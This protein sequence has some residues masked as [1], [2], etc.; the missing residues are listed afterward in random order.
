MDKRI[1][2]LKINE[3]VTLLNDHDESTCYLV[4]GKTRALLIDT[5]NGW[6]NMAALC[7]ELTPLPVTVVNTHGHCDHIFGNVY[8]PE[9]RLHPADFA[10]HDEHFAFPQMRAA[11]EKYGLEPAK[12]VPLSVGET[13]DLGG[14]TLETI[15]LPG[16]TAGSVGL[17]DAE[18]RVLFSGDGVIPHVW[19]QLPE[20][21]PIEALRNTLVALKREHGGEFDWLLTG[22]ARGPEP[23]A[24]VDGI[25]TGCE[26]LLAGKCDNDRPYR[27]H[28]GESIAHRYNADENHCIVYDA[29]RL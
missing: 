2:A 26:Q 14:L 7:R 9:V 21:L 8:F 23:A 24:L 4:T 13:F 15:P 5:A 18:H 6:V 17:L 25:L 1:R 27:W 3:A 11:M 16:H 12:L 10:L 22:H 28:G 29:A 20:S 19:M